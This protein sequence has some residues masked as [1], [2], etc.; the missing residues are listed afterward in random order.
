MDDVDTVEYYF[1]NTA[2]IRPN[3][4]QACLLLSYPR[5]GCRIQLLLWKSPLRMPLLQ[6][7]LVGLCTV[8]EF[9]AIGAFHATCQVESYILACGFLQEVAVKSLLEKELCASR[10]R[11]CFWFQALKQ[12]PKAA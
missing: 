10:T 11:Q 1:S 8:L 9:Y 4:V 7:V 3:V 2:N 6:F 5:I 12:D